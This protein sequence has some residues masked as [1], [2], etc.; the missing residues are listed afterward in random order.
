MA[1]A[2]GF[3]P[4]TG[5]PVSALG[6]LFWAVLSSGITFKDS[7]HAWHNSGF[8]VVAEFLQE[9][10]LDAKLCF[11]SSSGRHRETAHTRITSHHVKFAVD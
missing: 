9:R 11:R 4:G 6:L 8:G 2:L 5:I 10:V 3:L 1:N 7:D